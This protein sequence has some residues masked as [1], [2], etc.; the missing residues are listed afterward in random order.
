LD[1]HKA[2]SKSGSSSLIDR[3]EAGPIPPSNEFSD[4]E[5]ESDTSN[6]GWDRNAGNQRGTDSDHWNDGVLD[7]QQ[8]EAEDNR[9][10]EKPKAPCIFF[11]SGGCSKG[12]DCA[13]AHLTPSLGNGAREAGTSNQPTPKYF[14]KKTLMLIDNDQPSPSVQHPIRKKEICKHHLMGRCRMGDSCGLKHPKNGKQRS[15]DTTSAKNQHSSTSQ[16]SRPADSGISAASKVGRIAPSTSAYRGGNEEDVSDAQDTDTEPINADEDNDNQS[17]GQD[18]SNHSEMDEQGEEKDNYNILGILANSNVI[19]SATRD[20]INW[21]GSH[22]DE[23]RLEEI[24][25]EVTLPTIPQQR[26]HEPTQLPTTTYPHVSEVSLQVHWS[27]F[28]DPLANPEIPF[29]KPH[30]QGQ[31]TQGES[32]RFRHSIT[33]EEYNILFRDQQPNLWTLSRDQSAPHALHY[34]VSPPSFSAF[35]SSAYPHYSQ[36]SL[37]QAPATLVQ[38]APSQPCKFY[39]LGTCRNG[40]SCPY[41]HSNPPVE[42]ENTPT[43]SEQVEQSWGAPAVTQLKPDLQLCKYFGS[44]KGCTRGAFC[45]FSHGYSSGDNYPSSGPSGPRSS[46]SPA[47]EDQENGWTANWGEPDND[48]ANNNGW[49]QPD[50]SGWDTAGTSTWDKPASTPHSMPKSEANE[51]PPTDE[52]SHSAPWVVGPVPS[53]HTK[54]TKSQLRHDVEAQT[55]GATNGHSRPRSESPQ[56]KMDASKE[57]SHDQTLNTNDDDHQWADSKEEGEIE[58]EATAD[59]NNEE[60]KDAEPQDLIE[61]ESALELEQQCEPIPTSVKFSASMNEL[62]L[63]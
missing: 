40:N 11:P 56:P 39:P 47:I 58:A 12:D 25:P 35:S 62:T 9:N 38:S 16:P 45:T 4:G 36:V 18:E 1:S 61:E 21:P 41:F 55:Q 63:N 14:L 57:T 59:R 27:Q 49:G 30:A 22:Y 32:C 6:V 48:T 43:K 2:G 52:S 24:Q 10:N 15:L 34:N 19:S 13:F 44:K 50:Q 7:G 31:C 33:V 17:K 26:V 20:D 29:C 23:R 37:P 51:W 5:K 28:A 8:S 54:S 42:S 3:K 46:P 53:H 60:N